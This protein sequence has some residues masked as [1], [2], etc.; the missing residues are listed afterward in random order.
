M[1][2]TET[3]FYEISKVL[4]ADEGVGKLI[5]VAARPG[6][7]K[8]SLCHRIAVEIVMLNETK[9]LFFSLEESKNKLI[10]IFSDKWNLAS[11][12]LAKIRIEDTPTVSIDYIEKKI[13]EIPD[14]SVV[15]ID[16]IE[17]I[18]DFTAGSQ[19]EIL[20]KLKEICKSKNISIIYTCNINRRLEKRI[21][22]RPILS[23]LDE[24]TQKN[25]DTIFALYR[26]AYYMG[27]DPAAELRTLKNTY[28]ELIR[29]PL[30][31]DR[32]CL[33]FECDDRNF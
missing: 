27:D 5:S 15:L 31:F 22:K 11:E 24:Y 10:N 25:A 26:E 4:N 7:G 14:L 8:T 30:I 1:K 13:S 32:K 18:K 23:D 2:T 16:Y 33:S 17:L 29:I 21:N 6:M 3:L 9:A 19:N 12:N 28:G 20:N